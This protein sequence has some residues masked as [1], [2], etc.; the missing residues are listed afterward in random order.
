MRPVQNTLSRPPGQA[1]QPREPG[2]SMLPRARWTPDLASL[3]RGDEGKRI[4]THLLARSELR[5]LRVSV[6][7]PSRGC[8]QQVGGGWKQR[9]SPKRAH[10]TPALSALKGGEGEYDARNAP[11]SSAPLS[12]LPPRCAPSFSPLSL[13]SPP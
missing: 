4:G 12:S 7:N 9:A 11:V 6:V 3:V 5:V 1:A 8:P 13:P 10:L 2:T